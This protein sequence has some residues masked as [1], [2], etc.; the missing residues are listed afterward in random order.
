MKRYFTI[1]VAI[2]A[3]AAVM[4]SCGGDDDRP[5]KKDFT[6]TVTS[7]GNG[8]VETSPAE[9]NEG[10][11]VILT[12]NP[13]EGYVFSSWV[14]TSGNVELEKVTDNPAAFSMPAG[15]VAVQAKFIKVRIFKDAVY[16]EGVGAWI[17]PQ[18]DPYT[19]EN[20]QQAYA[21]LSANDLTRSSEFSVIKN[22]TAT[23]YAIKIFPKNEDE[24]WEI[25]LTEDVEVSYI[26]FTYIGLTEK[27]AEKIEPTSRASEMPVFPESNPYVVTDN[28]IE[29]TVDSIPAEENISQ[30]MPILYAVWPVNKPLPEHI[31]YEKDYDVFLPFDDGQTR[32]TT[33]LSENSLRLLENEAI[34]LALG[35]V[36]PSVM[37]AVTRAETVLRGEFNTWDALTALRIPVPRIKVK[38]HLGSNIVETDADENG[39]FSINAGTI[40]ADASWEV[41][42]Q[43]PKWKVTRENTTIPKNFFQGNVYQQ[44]FWSNPATEVQPSVQLTDATIINALNYYYYQP[45]HLSRWD[46]PGGIRVIAHNDSNSG[47]NGLFTYTSGNSCYIT[48]FR[49]NTVNRNVLAGTVLHELGHFIQF[50]ERGGYSNMK[51]VDK[52]LQESFASYVGWYLTGEYYKDMG[53]YNTDEDDI[54]G[55]GRQT[56][57]KT[58]T[59]AIGYYSPL[60]VDLVDSYNQ[61]SYLGSTFNNDDVKNLHYSVI[62]KIAKESADWESC[63]S[64]LR[65]ESGLTS[66]ELDAFLEPYEYWYKN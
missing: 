8:S 61:A 3:C 52:L 30:V 4:T 64:I 36:S 45:H 53:Y 35:Y 56:W 13:N 1:P 41:I 31:E 46:V 22:L 55:Q 57:R 66:Q 44:D 34:R 43:S 14:V 12:A 38:F 23:H 42:F 19:L 25:E 6:V 16:H 62:M 39:N 9:A 18:E 37:P 20:F 15:N 26:P 47:Y 17:A 58:R 10:E 51:S 65:A 21:N 40:P 48:I 50:K 7:E 29:Q 54:S 24:Q 33:A 2:L 63:K 32:S 27:E 49:N 28:E 5:V 60:F 59:G 11:V